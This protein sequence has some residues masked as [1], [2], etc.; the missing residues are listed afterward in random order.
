V[1]YPLI[2]LVDLIFQLLT[3]FI[4]ADVIGSWILAARARLPGWAYTILGV[5]HAVTAPILAPIRRIIPS[6]G[7]LDLSPIIAL[8][9]LEILRRLVRNVLLGVF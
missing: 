4:L 7:G 8:F 6:F 3:L 1:I 9:A 5:I 2:G